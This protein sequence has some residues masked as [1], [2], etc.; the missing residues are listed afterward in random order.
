LQTELTRTQEELADTP[1]DAQKLDSLMDAA[2]IDA[3][4]VTSKHNVQYLL[5]GYRFFF[6]DRMDAIGQ[7][8]YLPILIYP[9]GEAGKSAY[10]GN[11]MES[12]EQELTPLWVPEMHP[13]FWGA[14][15]ATAAAS[16]YLMRIGLAS[17]RIGVETAFLPADAFRELQSALPGATFW[18][19]SDALDQLRAVKTPNELRFMREASERVIDAMLTV[20]ASH[21]PGVT[22]R[23][24]V[25]ALRREEQARDLTYE[26]C[27]TTVG[28]S[29]NRAPSSE[30]TWEIGQPL[31]LDSG[32]TLEGYIGDVCR[33][34]VLGEPDSELQQ[35][36]DEVL[37]IQDTAIARVKAGEVGG[38]VQTTGAEAA[39]RSPHRD[40]LHFVAHGVGLVSH[41]DPHLTNTGPVPY[42]ADD[43]GAPLKPGMVLSVETTL[44]HPRRGFI[45]LEDTVA[46][47]DNGFEIFGDAG[48]LLNRGK[49]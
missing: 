29:H 37:T 19:A 4:F 10:F 34:G 9:R 5:G 41:E 27:L 35:L 6:F 21:G 42:Q 12:F 17:G 26:Y 46:V 13:N 2:G 38:A 40:N 45:K 16:A 22:K 11:A 49:F 39:C 36:F 20:F 18:R 3:L 15:D 44:L 31:S 1:F 24:L 43:A 8:R 14:L 32:A 33:M 7:S 28:T 47:T 23:E 48:R 30:A 25:A